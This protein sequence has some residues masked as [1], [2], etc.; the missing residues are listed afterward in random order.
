M[1]IFMDNLSVRHAL[2]QLHTNRNTNGKTLLERIWR[3]VFGD[4]AFVSVE[5]D[6]QT[7]NVEEF[8][9]KNVTQYCLNGRRIYVKHM[10]YELKGRSVKPKLSS[11]D[12]NFFRALD[13]LSTR[14]FVMVY[15]KNKTTK[16]YDQALFLDDFEAIQ[17]ISESEANG[18]L[19]SL[20]QAADVIRKQLS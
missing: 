16:N 18:R 4:K 2:A 8:A 15:V 12:I 7:Q 17:G 20:P 14:C 1:Y 5:K 9:V 10:F 19:V 13:K 3:S 11:D 6:I